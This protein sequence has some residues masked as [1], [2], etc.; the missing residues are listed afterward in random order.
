[1][2]RNLSEIRVDID[3]IDNRLQDLITQRAHLAEEVAAAKYAAED[4][5]IF[6]RPE[7]EADVLRRIRS[8]NKGPLTDETLTLLFREIMSACL[9]LQ[10]PLSVAYL[11]PEGTY[12]QAAA[13]KQFG[14]AAKTVPLQS[15]DEVF[16]EV[17]AGS[18]MYGI[19]PI[20]N[21]TEGGVNQTLDSFISA[22]QVRICGE[23]ELP[24]H[25]HLL[26]KNVDQSKIKRIYSHPQSLAQCRVWLDTHMPNVE[27]IA[28]GSNAEA[29]NFVCE[30]MDAAAIAGEQAAEIYNLN[31][32]QSRVEDNVNNTTRFA[33]LGQQTVEPTGEDKTTLI[34]ST[35]NE[36]GALYRLLATFAEHKISMSRIESRPSSQGNWD[37]VFFIDIDGH[38]NDE[39][40]K[41]MWDSLNQTSYLI[42]HLG[43]YPKAVC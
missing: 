28:M 25:Q 37:Y 5:P 21:S 29:A 40:V 32:L 41:T 3:D 9:G 16:R 24:I 26:S 30:H 22:Q 17:E 39:H 10:L 36:A 34:L 23:V 1:M 38:I 31:I 43:S 20:E 6:Y 4:S 19:V 7:R 13:L 18:V 14:H 27:R 15:I 11:G 33:V 8:N 12:S 42:K 2:A 35:S